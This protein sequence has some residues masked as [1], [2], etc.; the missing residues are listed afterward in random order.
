MEAQ[1]T[2]MLQKRQENVLP[3][4]N[5]FQNMEHLFSR[6]INESSTESIVILTLLDGI[7]VRGDERT[8]NALN[9]FSPIICN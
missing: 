5:K 4:T 7:T 6:M 3:F 8:A 1:Q 2:F 9:T